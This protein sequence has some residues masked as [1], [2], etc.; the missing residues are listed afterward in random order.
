MAGL[1]T[2]H[3]IALP[4]TN[5]VTHDSR[6]IRRPLGKR[7]RRS[8]VP[9]ATPNYFDVPLVE[10]LVERLTELEN[11]P[12]SGAVVLA[13]EGKHFCAGADF[14]GTS[15]AAE[16]SADEGA[17]VR[18]GAA[19]RMAKTKLPIVAAV[20]GG[21]IGGGLELALAADLRVASAESRLAANSLRHPN[22]SKKRP[23]SGPHDLTA[24]V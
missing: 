1:L 3:R 19:V 5:E 13:S 15:G 22:S 18:Y 24:M 11:G 17:R 8:R 10:A 2:R 12:G 16:V 9:P 14:A 6:S 23:R 21:A 4:A 7:C 20:Q